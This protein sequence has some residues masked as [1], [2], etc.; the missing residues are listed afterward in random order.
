LTLCASPRPPPPLFSHRHSA[1][2][3]S[4]DTEQMRVLWGIA[5]ESRDYFAT[6]RDQLWVS[7]K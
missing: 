5:K 3:V 4:D 7:V 6:S 1:R 2:S